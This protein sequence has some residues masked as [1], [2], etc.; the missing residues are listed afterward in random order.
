MGGTKTRSNISRID[1]EYYL[2]DLYSFFINRY[3][4]KD[5]IEKDE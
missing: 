5:W 1:E 3:H 2:D 4:L